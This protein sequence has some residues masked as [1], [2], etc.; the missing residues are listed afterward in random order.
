MINWKKHKELRNFGILVGTVF[1]GISLWPLV[2]G[3]SPIFW[4]S[5][6]A[7]VLIA[8]A[9]IWPKGLSPIY[10][11]WMKIGEGLGWVNTRIILGI[12]FYGIFTPIG[13]VMRVLGKDPLMK[14][15]NPEVKS[16]W[17]EKKE[18]DFEESMKFQF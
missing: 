7:G 11:V 4:L 6:L 14:K 12:F 5:G 10:S 3:L 13:V 17:S 9:I 8:A 1:L 15:P 18:V 16:Y 2:K